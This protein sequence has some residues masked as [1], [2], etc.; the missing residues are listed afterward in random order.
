MTMRQLAATVGVS[1]GSQNYVEPT[2]GST[3][4]ADSWYQCLCSADVPSGFIGNPQFPTV[5]PRAMISGYLSVGV[6][7]PGYRGLTCK[8]RNCPVGDTTNG[9]N[10]V[11]GNFGGVVEIQKVSCS[12]PANGYFWLSFK[13]QVTAKIYATDLAKDIKQKL[14]ELLTI[15]N[16]S[17]G[18]P[19]T[20]RNIPS[21]IAHY[22]KACS[23]LFN[24]TFGMCTCTID[25]IASIF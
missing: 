3:W 12:L 4:D 10:P 9:R 24:S 5:T 15:G 13:G 22:A 21:S 18:F 23:S 19:Q 25:T 6:S 7:L 1:Y 14:E 11:G 20:E 16:V 8:H 2:D 17:I